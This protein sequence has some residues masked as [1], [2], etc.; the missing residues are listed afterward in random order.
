ML[1]DGLAGV[2]IEQKKVAMAKEQLK[3]NVDLFRLRW[4]LDFIKGAGQN[5]N[6]SSVVRNSISN[7]NNDTVLHI[8]DD[9]NKGMMKDTD[10]I[11]GDVVTGEGNGSPSSPST[12]TQ[13]K[14]F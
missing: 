9:I 7:E 13:Y 11:D 4:T 10:L 8:L 2:F 6:P 5:F 14:N 12:Q 3:H 1:A